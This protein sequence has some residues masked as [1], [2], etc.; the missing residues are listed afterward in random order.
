ML[1]RAR[2]MLILETSVAKSV[3]E[4]DAITLITKALA[5]SG[6]PMPSAL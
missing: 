6:L 4:A 5:K 3:S 1:D 2:S